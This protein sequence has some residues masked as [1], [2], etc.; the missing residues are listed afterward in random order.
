MPTGNKIKKARLTRGL[1]QK[2]L[3]EKVGLTDVRIR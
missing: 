3:G 2:E 1:T